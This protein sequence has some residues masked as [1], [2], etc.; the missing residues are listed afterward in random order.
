[1]ATSNT[2]P[3]V[4]S[5]ISSANGICHG[6]G[7]NS[8]IF[9]IYASVKPGT[10]IDDCG[11]EITQV[12]QYFSGIGVDKRPL[13]K[14]N[15]GVTGEG[16]EDQI[17]DVFTYCCKEIQSKDD[18]IWLFG[19]SRGAYVVRVVAALLTRFTLKEAPDNK[20][21]SKWNLITRLGG[22]K[23]NKKGHG[24]TNGQEFRFGL[25]N[26][27]EPPK[28]K[29]L[30]LFDTVKQVLVGDQFDGTDVSFV[31]H[32]RHALALNEERRA[33]PLLHIETK[34]E[35]MDEGDNR[36]SHLEAWFV[37]AHADVGG[38]AVHD[39]LSLYPLQWMLIESRDLGLVLEH[40]PPDRVKG[41]IENP[42]ELVFPR[43]SPLAA[44]EQQILGMPPPLAAVDDDTTVKPG[45]WT[46]RYSSGIEISM[47]DLRDS[48]QHGNLQR[49]PRRKLQKQNGE[50]NYQATHL[51][52]INRGAFGRLALGKRRIFGYDGFGS[53]QGYRDSSRN[54][55][56][57]HPSVYFLVDTYTTL[58]IQKALDGIQDQLEL[59]RKKASMTCISNKAGVLLDPWIREI[60]P[61]FTS[62]RIL[63]CGNT[64][65]G[66]STLLNRV[67]GIEMT[68][69]NTGQ[70]GEHD[71]EEGFESDQ[72]PGIIIHDSEGFQAG[73]SKEVTA[74]KKFLKARSGNVKV[75]DNLH[76]IWLCIDT[77]T[78]RPVQSALA[79]VLEGVTAIAPTIPIV[80]VGTKKDK[81]ILLH[82][83]QAGNAQQTEEDM[84]SER[85]ALFRERFEK[86]QETCSFWPQLDVKFAFVSRDD[87][88]SI[89]SLIHLTMGS[90]N[91]T[92]VTEAM[93]AAQIPDVEAKIDQAVEKTL[94]ILRTAVAAASA[95]FGTGII[96][97]MT[98]PTIARIL[99]REIAHGCFGL[100]EAGIAEMD[101]ILASVV[102]KNLAPFMA[103]SLSQSVVIFG[104]AVCLTMFTVVGG[105]PLAVGAPLLEAPA[106]VRMVFKCACDLILV[107]EKAYR[108]GGKAVSR[109]EV[110][111]VAAAYMKSKVPVLKNGVQVERSRKRAVHG[112]VNDLVP[113]LSKRAI[114]AHQGKSL[115]KYRRG[116]KSI[117]L[118]YRLP[119]ELGVEIGSDDDVTLANSTAPYSPSTHPLINMGKLEVG[120]LYIMISI[121]FPIYFGKK[122][123]SYATDI[124]GDP[125][126]PFCTYELMV[127]EGL[128][129]EEFHWDL[130][131]HTSDSL[132]DE[133]SPANLHDDTGTGNNKVN[134]SG[135]IDEGSGVLYRLRPRKTC[136]QTYTLD[137]LSVVRIRSHTQV[138][139]LI[140]VLSVPPALAPHLT[141]YLDWMTAASGR[142]A[143]RTY[144]WAT[145][146]YYRARRHL[147]KIRGVRDHTFNQFDISRF[148]AELLSFAYEEVPSALLFGGGGVPRPVVAS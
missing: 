127:S 36:G 102:W 142:V 121:P 72:H 47:Y 109:E 56:V 46:F 115:P 13:N 20:D 110:R 120:S 39:G 18:E 23:R 59:F 24:A 16:C 96:S 135:D 117:L 82:R 26:T 11:N 140:R 133:S 98:T 43:S 116:I 29:F 105:I 126:F 94:K 27:R 69:E 124:P 54:G 5:V 68:Q 114:E 128:A 2:P 25:E 71:I 139:G 81:H 134:S 15:D 100:P 44:L 90:F 87:Q 76:A 1:M 22:R 31:Q 131:W 28:I 80:I 7:N 32:V 73:N 78:D 145:M 123:H 108:S 113:W 147:L 38:G 93:C 61:T 34:E 101:T 89:K 84:L 79:N 33:F 130:Y 146:A 55:T 67:F 9:R 99:C 12:V 83:N 125:K 95:G 21:K 107:L 85:Q 111:L 75:R 86:E 136:P 52:S 60:L 66:K 19:F 138:V 88:E 14:W 92:V 41:L 42:L 30:G 132:S 129:T 103:Q 144:V 97:S 8:N 45:P 51:V 48:H 58:G 118:R 64:G 112:E 57:V 62:C 53:L 77:D 35:D 37:G 17:K 106:A 122:K 148:T 40:N 137:R 65:V 50:Q 119:E 74:F 10:V 91:D 143:E 63:I 6:S 70:R 141:R 104:G 49:L 3:L 4:S